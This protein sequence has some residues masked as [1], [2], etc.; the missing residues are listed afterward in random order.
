MHLEP[1]KLHWKLPRYVT[2]AEASIC[3]AMSR[4]QTLGHLVVPLR[5]RGWGPRSLW[6][7]AECPSNLASWF[8]LSPGKR[9]SNGNM[10]LCGL[11]EPLQWNNNFHFSIHCRKMPKNNST[12]TVISYHQLSKHHL[13]VGLSS[14]CEKLLYIHRFLL[15]SFEEKKLAIRSVSP[16]WIFQLARQPA[17]SSSTAP[18]ELSESPGADAICKHAK[19][20]RD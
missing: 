15:D 4:P 19:K 8:L 11:G 13:V 3:H 7:L 1:A 14:H 6:V 2:V 17:N 10:K 16:A 5:L 9:E 18:P 20:S 12:L